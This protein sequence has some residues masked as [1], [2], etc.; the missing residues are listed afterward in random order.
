MF[1]H[2]VYF[3]LRPDL[4]PADRAA[5]TAGVESIC[6][7]P[8]VRHAWHGAPAATDRPIIDRTYSWGLTVVFDDL[9]GHDAYQ[10]HPVHL[11]FVE[12]HREKWTKVQI[13]DFE[14]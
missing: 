10:D 8:S 7:T 12:Q 13:Y 2:T 1:V 4:S 6:R 9:A 3:W 11:R 5:F 14:T